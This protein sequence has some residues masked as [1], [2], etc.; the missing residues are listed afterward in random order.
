M[1]VSLSCV[2]FYA[3]ER[4]LQVLEE[5][6]PPV[7]G[8][9]SLMLAW[10]AGASWSGNCVGT[11]PRCAYVLGATQIGNN[12]ALDAY[13]DK[14]LGKTFRWMVEESGF[15]DATYNPSNPI[16][17]GAMIPSTFA[18]A[19]QQVFRFRPL[20]NSLRPLNDPTD[21]ELLRAYLASGDTVA[22]TFY[23]PVS[24]DSVGQ[25]TG[26]KP[27]T[28]QVAS[29]GEA[30]GTPQVVFPIDF[31]EKAFTFPSPSIDCPSDAWWIVYGSRCM[32]CAA[33]Q[34]QINANLTKCEPGSIF[35]VSA[36]GTQVC[37]ACPQGTYE[38]NH[39]ACVASEPTGFS[40]LLHQPA[41]C[42]PSVHVLSLTH[43]PLCSQFHSRGGPANRL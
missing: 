4:A 39:A 42:T 10:Y 18:Q 8:G 22:K 30:A 28:L 29:T 21:Y 15:M 2:P 38:L 27:T 24:F 1:P 3:Q 12:E 25:N 13:V 37:R 23:G 19:L 33:E 35:T 34:C 6:R 11:G 40:A 41:V 43:M 7:A 17:D 26:R 32:L 36:G 14:L 20:T 5:A 16:P 31:A 9:H